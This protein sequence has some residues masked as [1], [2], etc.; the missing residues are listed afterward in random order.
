MLNFKRSTLIDASIEVVWGFHKRLDI[1]D[2][3]TPSYQL[4]QVVRREG[5]LEVGTI[6]EFRI[7][8]DPIPLPWLAVHAEYEKYLLFTDKQ[9]EGPFEHWVHCHQFAAEDGK[10]RLTDEIEF[11]LPGGS[12]LNLYL[13]GW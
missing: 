6:S 11:A 5:G 1:L 13:V 4:M 8:V 12:L 2:L 7:F 3:L 9:Q 10:T